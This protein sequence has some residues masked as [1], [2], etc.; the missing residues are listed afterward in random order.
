[1]PCYCVRGY[2]LIEVLV[3]MLLLAAGGLGAAATHMAG[4]RLRQHTALAAEALALGASL[5][6]RI[7]VNPAGASGPAGAY[8]NFDYDSA[9]GV[10]PAPARQC[11]SAAD[12]SPAEL[13]AF[14]LFETALT[15]ERNFPGGRIVLCRDAVVWNPAQAAL[16]WDCTGGADAALVVKLG[17]RA[18]ALPAPAAAAL[19]FISLVVA[20]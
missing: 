10:P 8:L 15:I 2:T 13:A 20:G 5:A 14:D 7:R 3:A 12:C 16:D 17:W 11:F 9:S 4:M 1:M 19:P 18:R 6:A